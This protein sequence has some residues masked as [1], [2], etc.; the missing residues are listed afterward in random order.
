MCGS[1]AVTRVMQPNQ[2]NRAERRELWFTKTNAAEACA[3]QQARSCGLTMHSET[4]FYPRGES[5]QPAIEECG[6]AL[7]G[8]FGR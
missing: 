3:E 6:L 8:D 4:W 1:A 2:T 7:M 5:T